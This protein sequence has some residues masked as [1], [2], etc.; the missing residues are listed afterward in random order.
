M[1]IDSLCKEMRKREVPEQEVQDQMIRLMW[2]RGEP[3]CTTGQE[4]A[5]EDVE[6]AAVAGEVRAVAKVGDIAGTLSGKG[7][8][9]TLHVVGCC[10]RRPGV[11]YRIQG[12]QGH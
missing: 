8:V 10:H 2:F 3:T 4:P 9:K 5:M 7:A 12:L 1:A 11:D 6:M